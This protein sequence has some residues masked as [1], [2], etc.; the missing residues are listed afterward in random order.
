MNRHWCRNSSLPERD[1][2]TRA[3]KERSSDRERSRDARRAV[4]PQRAC[5][6]DGLVG[7]R[8]RNRRRSS[9][10]AIDLQLRICGNHPVQR[11]NTRQQGALFPAAL[12]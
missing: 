11:L 2:A 4:R 8:Q 6:R 10:Y 3:G 12:L 7:R 5:R 9:E 1:C